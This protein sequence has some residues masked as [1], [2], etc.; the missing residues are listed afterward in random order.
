M[1]RQNA[2]A[3][4][5]A[6]VRRGLF[7]L[8]S[9][10]SLLLCVALC[11]L[12]ARSYWVE[13]WFERR[14]FDPPGPHPH[15]LDD[16]PRMTDLTAVAARGRVWVLVETRLWLNEVVTMRDNEWG[17]SEMTEWT[18]R[19]ATARPGRPN[20]TWWT[21]RGFR[22]ARRHPRPGDLRQYAS[23]EVGLPLWA[24]ALATALLPAIWIRGATRNRRRRRAGLCPACGYDLRA[25]PGRCPE[26]GTAPTGAAA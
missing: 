7:T 3:R 26:C 21:R 16:P 19:P 2:V 11:A 14:S 4:Y 5:T 6:R 10:V 13:D 9:A 25:T 12:W 20:D 24:P 1:R 22:A 17:G 18:R 8:C 23:W 15:G